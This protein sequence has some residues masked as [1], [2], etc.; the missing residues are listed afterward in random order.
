MD[1]GDRIGLGVVVCGVAA[2]TSVVCL[3]IAGRAEPITL[4]TKVECVDGFY[5]GH[6]GIVKDEVAGSMY[7]D[8]PTAARFGEKRIF[9]DPDDLRVLSASEYR[10][11]LREAEWV[12]E[13]EQAMSYDEN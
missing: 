2:I 13:Y 11:K 3:A 6:V 8:S 4:G 12:W 7:I 1:V 10:A 5:K 9:V